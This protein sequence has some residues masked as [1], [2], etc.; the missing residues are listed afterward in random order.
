VLFGVCCV[1]QEKRKLIYIV[2]THNRMH[3]LK[4]NIYNTIA[5]T[6]RRRILL[7]KLTVA[8]LD[9]EPPAFFWGGGNWIIMALFVVSLYEILNRV[10][11]IQCSSSQLAFLRSIS[12]L[13]LHLCLCLPPG[14]QTKSVNAFIHLSRVCYIFSPFLIHLMALMMLDE[15]NLWNLSSHSFLRLPVTS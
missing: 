2:L 12:M 15:D 13:S 3:Y 7:Q 6:P 14:F 4:I 9:S 1:W 5:W 8:Q 10:I 11:Q